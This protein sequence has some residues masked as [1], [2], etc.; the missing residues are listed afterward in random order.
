MKL[1]LEY[2]ILVTQ[3]GGPYYIYDPV[4]LQ[5][6]SGIMWKASDY[7]LRIKSL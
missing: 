2:L 4:R 7:S 5:Q 1:P 3:K 6:K